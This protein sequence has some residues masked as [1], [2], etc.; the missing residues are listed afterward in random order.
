MRLSIDHVTGFRYPTP[1]RASFNEARMTP[2]STAHQVVWTSRLT[3]LPGPWRFSYVD[4]WGTAVTCFEV[5]EPHD[6]LEVAAMALVETR[7]HPD[8]WAE[9]RQVPES[10]PDWATLHGNRVLDEMGEYLAQ[11]TRTT[12]HPTLA[13]QAAEFADRPPRLAA[14]DVCSLVHEHLAYEVGATAVTSTAAEAW[15][16]GRG[17]CQD[18]SHV[19]CGALRSLGIP[20][21]YVSGYVHPAGPGA[22]R[23]E[24]V[25]SE[26]HSWVEFWCGTW[27][28][29]DPTA[30]RTPTEAYVRVGHGRDYGD[31]SPLRGTY[32]GG[33]SEMFVKVTI[34][35][36]S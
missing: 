19:T 24:V 31:V 25:E 18:F 6:R 10:D 36:L 1:V 26:S 20:A 14:L 33:D 21:R 34:T 8:S 15:E 32:A 3:I 23:G 35:A 2:T 5:H 28:A 22:P 29:Y 9:D 27:L 7:P 17:V 16:G 11:S 13:A 30:M 4:Y 12:P